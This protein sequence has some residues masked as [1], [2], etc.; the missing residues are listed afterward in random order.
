MK[1]YSKKDWWVLL[2]VWTAILLPSGFGFIAI[3]IESE[4]PLV[5]S[6]W[7]A[8]TAALLFILSLCA[9]SFP[10]YYEVEATALRIHSG[11]LQQEIPLSSIQAVFPTRNPLV[12][13][14]WSLDRLQV[15]Y[16][17]GKRPLCA[18]IAPQ[19][20]EKFLHELAEHDTGLEI[21]TDSVLRRQ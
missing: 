3:H 9:L 18:L 4:L 6:G 19:D 20:K 14:A 17:L 21:K 16:Q 15:N 1:Y 2:V 5:I 8:L 11:L 12:A 7:I 10:L 13:A